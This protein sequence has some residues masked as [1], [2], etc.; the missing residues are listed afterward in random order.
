[1]KLTTKLM[2]AT[3]MVAAPAV[4]A[5][6]LEVTHWWTSGGEAAALGVLK[7]G[8]HYRSLFFDYALSSILLSFM[9]P[10]M[11]MVQDLS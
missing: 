5:A 4:H 10:L 9:Q 7:N 1:M 11:G 6:E 3:A 8:F 2:A